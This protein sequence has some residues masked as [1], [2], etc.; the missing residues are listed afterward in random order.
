MR[1]LLA[2]DDDAD[3][4]FSPAVELARPTPFLHV[5]ALTAW[6][7]ALGPR[8][9]TAA[10]EKV[11]RARDRRG[12]RALGL[13]LWVDRAAAASAT[14]RSRSRSGRR[15]LGRAPAAPGRRGGAPG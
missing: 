5:R 10:A 8:D 15:R 1:G 3:P 6:A 2:A 12:H 7:A 9:R 13:A 4:L 14:R 11:R